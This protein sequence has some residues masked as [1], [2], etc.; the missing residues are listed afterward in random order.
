MER[1]RQE[2]RGQMREGARGKR[3]GEK[4]GTAGK[5]GEGEE[6]NLA[7]WS[8]LKVGAYGPGHSKHLC[9]RR[10]MRACRVNTFGMLHGAALKNY[11]WR[12]NNE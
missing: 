3:E 9:S 11:D 1:D 5:G 12:F 10:K 8:F 2:G 4:G 7:I 6:G